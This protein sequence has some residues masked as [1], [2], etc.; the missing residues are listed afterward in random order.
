MKKL[1]MRVMMVATAALTGLVFS[2]CMAVSG[3]SGTKPL[4]PLQQY[5]AACTSYDMA[6][7]GVTLLGETGKIQK[8]V[9][10][11]MILASHQFTP[12]CLQPNP[13]A[14]MTDVTK[15]ITNALTNGVLQEGLQY[16]KTH[17][18]ALPAVKASGVTKP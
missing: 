12:I 16:M 3:L 5:V 13:P 10:D 2:G 8:P 1:M 18:T 6:L 17:P 14:N 9:I 4:T 7:Q 15:Q 11:Q